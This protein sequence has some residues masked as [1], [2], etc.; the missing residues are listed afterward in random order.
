MLQ[1]LCYSLRV[2]QQSMSS[3]IPIH[4][5][6]NVANICSHRMQIKAL[7]PV[8][9]DEIPL[10][11]PVDQ[12]TDDDIVNT[13]DCAGSGT[14]G[15]ATQ[16]IYQ[17]KRRAQ[18]LAESNEDLTPP[19]LQAR[20][21]LQASIMPIP[22]PNM[23]TALTLFQ[24]PAVTPA[25][26]PSSPAT[27]TATAT[28]TPSGSPSTEFLMP[29]DY[30]AA[31]GHPT[32]RFLRQMM[33]GHPKRRNVQTREKAP[34][35]VC[36][37]ILTFGSRKGQQ[38][39]CAIRL[40]PRKKQFGFLSDAGAKHHNS[41]MHRGS[42]SFLAMEEE[43]KEHQAALNQEHIAAMGRVTGNQKGLVSCGTAKEQLS[44]QARWVF[45]GTIAVTFTTFG[46]NYFRQMM[47]CANPKAVFLNRLLFIKY[48]KA[49]WSNFLA[50]LRYVHADSRVQAAGNAYFQGQHDGVTLKENKSKYQG[51][52]GTL[53]FGFNCWTIAFGFIQCDD[54][55]AANVAEQFSSLFEERVGRPLQGCMS[56]C[57]SDVA[58]SKVGEL[59]LD[60]A[61]DGEL[62]CGKDNKKC[63]MHVTDKP[64]AM[65][66][67]KLVRTKNK[68]V[69]DGFDDMSDLTDLHHRRAIEFSYASRHKALFAHCVIKE[70]ACVKPQPDLCTTRVAAHYM[71]IVAQIRIWSANDAYVEQRV[72]ELSN[73]EKKNHKKVKDEVARY[74]AMRVTAVQWEATVEAE[75]VM[76]ALRWQS[77]VFQQ[78]SNYTGGMHAFIIRD[79]QRRLSPGTPLMVIDLAQ[80]GRQSQRALPRVARKDEDLTPMGLR[81][82]QIGYRENN[83]RLHAEYEALTVDQLGASYLDPRLRHAPH[84][85][86]AE[87]L[88]AKEIL[89]GWYVA[90]ANVAD[91]YHA[92]AQ[93]GHAA[94]IA[95][96][97]AAAAGV[98]VKA[99]MDWTAVAEADAARRH[100]Q[101]PPVQKP[102]PLSPMT[103]GI[104]G[105]M[106]GSDGDSDQEDDGQQCLHASDSDQEDDFA[107][108]DASSFCPEGYDSDTISLDPL[109]NSDNDEPLPSALPRPRRHISAEFDSCFCNWTRMKIDWLA[110]FPVELAGCKPAE[111]HPTLHLGGLEIG[112]VLASIVGKEAG[113]TPRY[114]WLPA[115][116]RAR[117]AKR[118][119]AAFSERLNSAAK[120]VMCN[121]RTTLDHANLE[122]LAVLRINRPFMEV[123][124]DHHRHVL[125]PSDIAV[126]SVVPEPIDLDEPLV[127]YNAEIQHCH[128]VMQK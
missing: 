64:L 117:L 90:F 127:D 89:R 75:A 102:T 103:L 21:N 11:E 92:A 113:R 27:A 79:T 63:G 36:I 35:H 43:M 18:A 82:K 37:D 58:A 112:V 23:P 101:L 119:S 98:K 55:K 124:N 47:L 7:E 80:I 5:V 3:S 24:A 17:N 22:M 60:E 42:K 120:M 33:Q 115:M 118:L 111:L 45:Y 4:A 114:G 100:E 44:A 107:A 40:V 116:A 13:G 95:W 51:F 72:K 6:N 84:L 68:K 15:F 121:G 74:K 32:F 81:A 39:G 110:L 97:A 69:I 41:L 19:A 70:L 29:V 67:G 94:C 123:M 104:T 49:E 128:F 83:L 66:A 57:V 71:M 91:K 78:D 30:S 109:S 2:K 9:A 59:L 48:L 1:N 105:M 61:E 12:D 93:A 31:K 54:G 53:D 65:V 52:S 56:G 125:G 46:D 50:Y 73:G 10:A 108:A 99:A 28:A 85:S 86:P 38:C 77:L 96:E 26:T 8:V 62:Y 14:R 122:M 34:T 106:D 20:A 88:K 76:N 16:T 87:K 126:A 25:V